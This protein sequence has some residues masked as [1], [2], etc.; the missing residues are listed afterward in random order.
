MNSRAYNNIFCNTK[1]NIQTFIE[2][3]N[4]FT[5]ATDTA[6]A[7]STGFLGINYW[8]SVP[9]LFPECSLTMGCMFAAGVRRVDRGG[10]SAVGEGRDRFSPGLHCNGRRDGTSQVPPGAPDGHSS[11]DD[12]R[13]DKHSGDIRRVFRE[14]CDCHMSFAA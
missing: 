13:D 5:K 6:A 3:F 10:G 4:T 11:R 7:H 8:T 9:C 12:T 1:I 14:A 2:L